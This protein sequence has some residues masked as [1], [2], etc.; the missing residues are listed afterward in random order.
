MYGTPVYPLTTTDKP[1][2]SSQGEEKNAVTGCYQEYQAEAK[3]H[4]HQQPCFT[5]PDNLGRRWHKL[6]KRCYHPQR[7]QNFSFK[8][9]SYNVLA[10][11]LL[12]SN[13]HLYNGSEEW[14]KDWDY[15]R[16]NLLKELLY[17][18]A[19]VLCLQ[20]VEVSHYEDWFEPKLREKGYTG[21]Y[22]QRSGDK[23][24]GC[25][26]FFRE[27]IF[28]LVKSELVSF[29][30][31]GVKLMDRHNVAV[32]VLLKPKVPGR[33]SRN[34][35][36]LVCISNTH[37]LFNPKRGDI[38]LAQ[39][40]FLFSEI[41]EIAKVSSSGQGNPA[42]HPIICCGDFNST[43]F[44]PIYEFVKRGY[45]KYMGMHRDNFSGQ[46]HV[47]RSYPPSQKLR[48]NIIPWELGITTS[49]TK[50]NESTEIESVSSVDQ[51]NDLQPPGLESA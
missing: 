32:V 42:Y 8:V 19:D 36:N 6:R 28:M 26:T 12:H 15:R 49:C 4:I 39:L 35:K 45:L 16:R 34:S 1:V 18:N 48:S 38:K 7:N 2:Q 30:K 23:T 20:E 37:L 29:N 10:D 43:P 41:E 13:S 21:V 44:S 14:L 3:E 9:V 50:R 22:K 17:Y 11:G 40:A 46:S 24:D 51:E 33:S 5:S 27:S 25:A 47:R 31:P